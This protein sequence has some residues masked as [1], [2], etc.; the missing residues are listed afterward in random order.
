MS[1]P[2]LNQGALAVDPVI[3]SF[4]ET[5]AGAASER[6]ADAALTARA[7]VAVTFAGAGFWYLLWKLAL[8]FVAG[9]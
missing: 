4:P 8:L 3:E 6:G 1:L 5:Q 9:H 2:A 7:V